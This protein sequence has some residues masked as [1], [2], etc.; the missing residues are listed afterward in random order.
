MMWCHTYD[1]QTAVASFATI[2]EAGTGLT[3][4]LMKL[5]QALLTLNGREIA[6]LIVI[7]NLAAA[8]IIGIQMRRRIK[9]DLGRKATKADLS[10][11]DT[12]MKVDQAEEQKKSIKP[13][14]LF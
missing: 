1:F 4:L 6:V 13:P 9:K 14:K 3:R 8:W 5:F 12:W 2:S 7:F 11:I 10:S